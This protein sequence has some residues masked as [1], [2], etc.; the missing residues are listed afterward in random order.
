MERPTFGITRFLKWQNKEE[1][2]SKARYESTMALVELTA[3][4]REVSSG[5]MQYRQKIRYGPF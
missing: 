4:D 3:D 2:I 5:K 1:A